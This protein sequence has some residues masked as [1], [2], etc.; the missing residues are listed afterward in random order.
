MKLFPHCLSSPAS[1]TTDFHLLSIHA[2]LELTAVSRKCG[3]TRSG[4]EFRGQLTLSL[5]RVGSRM[6]FDPLLCAKNQ[7]FRAVLCV[8]AAY[9][10][11]RCPSVSLSVRLSVTFMYSVE[12]NKHIFAPKNVVSLRCRRRSFRQVSWKSEGDCRP[13]RNVNK[14]SNIPY[15]AM[16]RDEEQWSGIRIWDRIITKS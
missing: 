3:S 15:S 8:S 16:V 14:I 6:L 1:T 2:V 5:F 13:M 9:A 4:G 11:V 7:L 12:T 10:V